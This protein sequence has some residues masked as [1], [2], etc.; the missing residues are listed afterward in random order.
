MQSKRGIKLEVFKNYCGRFGDMPAFSGC[1]FRLA[2]S[3]DELISPVSPQG[4]D[5]EI[6]NALSSY[7]GGGFKLKSP[8]SGNFTAAYNL[9]T[10]TAIRK[11]KQLCFMSLL[12][13]P[14]GSIWRSLIKRR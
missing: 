1:S 10:Q 4:D 9:L 11:T 5:A 13:I 3:V 2:S 6:Q 14:A 8:I 12:S 7:A